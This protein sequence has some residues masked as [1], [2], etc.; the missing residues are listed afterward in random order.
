[1]AVTKEEH[2]RQGLGP[3]V[4]LFSVPSA[5]NVKNFGASNIRNHQDFQESHTI[6]SA[7]QT[8]FRSHL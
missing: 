6:M 2:V 5:K 3:K 4:C 7:K 8:L 1:M